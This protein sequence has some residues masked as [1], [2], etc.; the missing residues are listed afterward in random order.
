MS[1][2]R[3]LAVGRIPGTGRCPRSRRTDRVALEDAPAYLCEGQWA[4]FAVWSLAGLA[5]TAAINL[6]VMEDRTLRNTGHYA[7]I[8]TD[9]GVIVVELYPE[10]APKT[11]ENFKKLVTQGFYDNLTFHRVVPGFV[12]QG[13]DPSG[14]GT[15]GPGY[16]VEGEI[17]ATE[18]HLRG[19]LATA[20]TG[21]EV[22][23]KRRSSGSQFYICLEPQPG[24][25]G[26]YTIF[27]AV[28]TGM[29]VVE[30]IKRGDRMKKLALS[31][32]A[33]A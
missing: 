28:I 10:V 11:V 5:R 20:R 19:T 23:P 12:V 15:G 4:S 14:N 30:K 7:T 25:D 1:S 21:D 8:D 2:P 29:D 3:V 32:K 17:E 6:S 16:D 13:G 31:D 22:N 9:R 26:Q 18:K 27:G 33:P 24:L